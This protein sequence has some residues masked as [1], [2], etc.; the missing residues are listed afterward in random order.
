MLLWAEMGGGMQGGSCALVGAITH[1]AVY[2]DGGGRPGDCSAPGV[3][4]VLCGPCSGHFL[5][6][7]L[8]FLS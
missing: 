8:D 3:S 2:P 7:S 4:E 5:P 1:G 6:G